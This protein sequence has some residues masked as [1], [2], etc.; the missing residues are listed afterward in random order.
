MKSAKILFRLMSVFV[1]LTIL[2]SS[3]KK[4]S[5][6]NRDPNNITP[7]D[8]APDYLMA[9]VLTATAT[10]YGNLGS[11]DMSGAVQ[12]TYVDAFGN[13]YSAYNWDSK[14][15]SGN[16]GILRDNKLMMQKSGKSKK[17]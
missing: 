1:V 9:N 11:G 6:M 12:H 3:C 2:V 13:S 4:F 15:W 14:S 17:I 8:A 16:Y 10:T 7:A 5:E